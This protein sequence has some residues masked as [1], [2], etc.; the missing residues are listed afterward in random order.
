[1]AAAMIS[2]AGMRIVRVLVGAPPRTITELI[3]E[4][5]VTRTAITEQ[6]TELLDAG[7]VQRTIQ[8]LAGRGR[9]RFIFAA[10]QAALVLLFASNQQLVVPA[11]WKAIRSAG[12]EKLTRK[13]VRN[14]TASLSKHYQAKITATEPKD[15]LRQYIAI[16]EREGGLV[17]LASKD[18]QVYV[19]KRN[20]PFIAMFEE[21]RNVCAIDLD[22]MAS[23]A[24]CPVRHVD[25]R[26]EGAPCCR[27]EVDTRA[28]GA[29]K[30]KR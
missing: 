8:P 24:G 5:G 28:G 18:G 25:C 9:P 4:V 17:E 12:G 7:Y 11:I 10:T 6:L 23:I 29:A 15:R 30:Q 16:L 19:T 26:H 27:F 14:V 22:L 13:I 3:D 2:A 1:M 20:C 21:E